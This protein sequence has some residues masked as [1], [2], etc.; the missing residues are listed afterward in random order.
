MISENPKAERE[1]KFNRMTDKSF[2]QIHSERKAAQ[3]RRKTAKDF[4]FIC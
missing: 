1:K 2:D 4:S 3:K